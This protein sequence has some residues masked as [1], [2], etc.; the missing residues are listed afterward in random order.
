M[1]VI[2][3]LLSETSKPEADMRGCVL[4]KLLVDLFSNKLTGQLIERA[5]YAGIYEEAFRKYYVD[6]KKMFRYAR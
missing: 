1:L 2:Q 6:E 5:E 3:R 4:E